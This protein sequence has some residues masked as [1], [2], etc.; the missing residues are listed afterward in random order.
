[1]KPRTVLVTLELVSDLPLAYLGDPDTWRTREL[2]E[3]LIDSDGLL[4]IRSGKAQV[5]QPA[6]KKKKRKR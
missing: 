1:M 2:T 4:E 3:H 5:A 6:N